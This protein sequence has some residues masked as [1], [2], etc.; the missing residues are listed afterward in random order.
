[1]PISTRDIV[2]LIKALPTILFAVS[3][4]ATSTNAASEKLYQKRFCDG[5][6]QNITTPAGTEADCLSDEFAIEV[7]KSKKW[8]EAIGQALHYASELNRKPAIILVC[9]KTLKCNAHFYHLESAIKAHKLP[10]S[11]WYCLHDDK[12]LADCVF[13]QAN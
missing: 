12:A 9:E 6:D 1:M 7:D 2:V 8:A 5:M 4:A 13:E 10:I 11:V 3:V